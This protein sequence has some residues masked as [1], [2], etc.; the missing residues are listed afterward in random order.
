MAF[1]GYVSY[2][3]RLLAEM[4]TAFGR[5]TDRSS[6]N[7]LSVLATVLQEQKHT[8][9][10]QSLI[11]PSLDQYNVLIW[12]HAS[13][14]LPQPEAFDRLEEWMSEGRLVIFLGNDHNAESD[15]WKDVYLSSLPENREWARLVYRRIQAREFQNDDQENLLGPNVYPRLSVEK[16]A[17]FDVVAAP[18][19]FFGRYQMGDV[20]EFDLESWA[21]NRSEETEENANQENAAQNGLPV[22][23]VHSYLSPNQNANVLLNCTNGSQTIPMMWQ[24]KYDPEVYDDPMRSVNILVLSNA[25]FLTNF[26][27]VRAENHPLLQLFL[28]QIPQRSDIVFLETGP[29]SVPLSSTAEQRIVNLWCWMGRAP[30][31][32]VTLHVL[33][34]AVIYCFARFPVF[35]RPK[36]VQFK[37]RNDFGQHLA[38]VGRLLRKVNQ[39]GFAQQKID[40]YFQVVKKSLIGKS[41]RGR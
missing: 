32:L 18:N 27:I 5:S 37:A 8:V 29:N 16:G 35:G 24:S 14:N 6:L 31:P 11:S 3:G 19:R 13:E 34:L 21:G 7:G 2:R 15:F 26:G 20:G 28:D 17:W 4:R 22:V 38:E 41:S 9:T 33:L 10:R 25:S 30:F 12:A 1:A 36:N 39:P 23:R 40:H